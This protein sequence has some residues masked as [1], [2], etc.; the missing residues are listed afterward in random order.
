MEEKTNVE[1]D[2]R[3][4][5]GK[6]CWA[7][8]IMPQFWGIGNGLVIGL[9][10]FMPAAYP[11]I[12]L[13]FGFKGYDLAYKK[14]EYSANEEEFCKKQKVWKIVSFIYA[15]VIITI[16]FMSNFS[17]LS[18]Y[19]QHKKELNMIISQTEEQKNRLAEELVKLTDVEN[20]KPFIDGL[21]CT[22]KGE[23]QFNE[24]SGL[25]TLKNNYGYKELSEEKVSFPQPTVY[26]I[27]QEFLAE[28]GRILTISFKVDEEFQ[29]QEG[30][31]SIFSGAGMHELSPGYYT[32]QDEIGPYMD[33]DTIREMLETND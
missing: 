25:W 26:D 20:L 9:L 24:N 17:G 18:N 5:A 4:L 23:V 11:F 31:Y 32:N 27:T 8:L 7:G 12:A 22:P 30:T 14:V 10:A 29:I 21:E 6:F 33:N 28:D 13:Y 15:I 3:P 2:N 19:F 16:I 1:N